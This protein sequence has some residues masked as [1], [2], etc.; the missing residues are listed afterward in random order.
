MDLILGLLYALIGQVVIFF[1]LQGPLKWK[2]CA[3]YRI[4]LAALGFPVTLL[5]MASVRHLA[6]AFNGTIWPSRLLG[7]AVGMIVFTG[8]AS[9]V[10]GEGLTSKTLVCL[11]LSICIVLVQ[12][13]WK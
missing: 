3:D 6:I 11:G 12:V 9:L 10:F 5:L 13:L 7:F 1:Q 8:L 4:E 2:W